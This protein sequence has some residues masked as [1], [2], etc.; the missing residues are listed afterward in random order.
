MLYA[1]PDA[2]HYA[3]DKPLANPP[4]SVWQYSSGTTNLISRSLREASGGSVADW[5]EFPKTRLFDKIGRTA[6]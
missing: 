1:K 5:L 6:P 4:G 2:G 3:A